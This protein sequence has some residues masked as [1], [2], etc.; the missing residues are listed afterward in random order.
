MFFVVSKGFCAEPPPI[1]IKHYI[2]RVEL[3]DSADHIKGDA[4]LTI[5]CLQRANRIILDLASASSTQQGMRVGRVVANGKAL[6]YTH[7]DDLLEITLGREIASGSEVVIDIQYDGTPR[8]GLIIGKNKYGDRTFFGDNWPNRAHHWLPVIDHP[9]DKASVEFIVTAPSRY[10]VIGNG[11]KVEESTI[12]SQRKLTHWK[13]V[14]PLCTKVMAIG[15]AQFAIQYA[16]EI[17]DISVEHWVY[18]QDRLA[19]FKDYSAAAKILQFLIMQIGPYPYKKLANVQSKT[20]YGGMENASNIFYSESSVNGKADHDDLIAHEIAHQWFGN[21]AAE[22]DWQDVW[23]SEGFA[24]YFANVYN[25]FTFGDDRRAQL[26]KEQRASIIDFARANPKLPVVFGSLPADLLDI[27][28]TNSYQKGSFIL[29][30][31]RKQIGE[32]AFWA[33]IREYYQKY[34]GKNA[35][36]ADFQAIM[37]RSSGADLKT[38]FKQWL[39]TPGHPRL[40]LKWSYNSATSTTELIVIQTQA[41]EAF[42]FPI[43]VAWFGQAAAPEGIQKLEIGEKISRF[44]IKTGHRPTKIQL[45]PSVNVLFEEDQIN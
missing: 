34:Q 4:T 1:D 28:N 8:D 11:V 30:M 38:F 17:D 42:A 45:D 35:A 27:L 18:P 20:R 41:G 24:T 10:E 15:V 6:S 43:E 5:L 7:H 44:S 9:A 40:K 16:A 3:N 25:E 13:E 2:F 26:M 29:H 36:T 22:S 23:L 31:L 32:K 21:S 33:G 14:V 19:G 12:D 37:E 39:Y